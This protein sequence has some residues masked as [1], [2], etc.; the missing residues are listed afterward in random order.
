MEDAVQSHGE[1]LAAA[2]VAPGAVLFGA[3]VAAFEPVALVV[4]SAAATPFFLPISMEV[5]WGFWCLGATTMERRSKG[6][7]RT[8]WQGRDK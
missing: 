4:A 6:R 3:A 2:M 1:S 8:G 5:F 7:R